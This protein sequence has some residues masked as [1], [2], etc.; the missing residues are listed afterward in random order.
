MA[1]WPMAVVLQCL[2]LDHVLSQRTQQLN[3]VKSQNLVQR[4]STYEVSGESTFSDQ[5]IRASGKA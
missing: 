2:G 3:R 5:D 1:F 4:C